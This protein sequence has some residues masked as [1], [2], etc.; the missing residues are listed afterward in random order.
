MS[1]TAD[2]LVNV[3]DTIV[4]HF[5]DFPHACAAAVQETER[6]GTGNW[7]VASSIPGSS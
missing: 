3:G 1:V 2:R 4:V 6:V 5:F 7:K